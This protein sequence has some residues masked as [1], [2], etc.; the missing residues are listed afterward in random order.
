[1]AIKWIREIV[2]NY[3]VR[4][5]EQDTSI[6]AVSA[7]LFRSCRMENFMEMYPDRIYNVGIAFLRGFV[8]R[9]I[10]FLLF[11]WLPF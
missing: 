4:L 7:D 1:M 5:A 9:D 3:M 11:L 2:G 10:L 6:V 8:M